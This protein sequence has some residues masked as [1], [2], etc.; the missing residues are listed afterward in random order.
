MKNWFYITF[1]NPKVN[2]KV[3]LVLM[4][5]KF[6]RFCWKFIKIHSLNAEKIDEFNRSKT[7]EKF[8]KMI[9]WNKLLKTVTNI[10]MN[11]W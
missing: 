11:R 6:R 1:E 4:K 2:Q 10:G 7:I 9:K 3:E 8:E 5:S